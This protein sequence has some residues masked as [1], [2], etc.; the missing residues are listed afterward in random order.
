MLLGTPSH[1]RAAS[2]WIAGHGSTRL[3]QGLIF[4]TILHWG[5]HSADSNRSHHWIVSTV[6]LVVALLFLVTAAR[7]L[8]SDDDPNVP[9]PKWMTMLMSATPAKAFFI[10]VGVITVSVKAWVFTLAAISVI[11]NADLG[12]VANV[13]SYGVFVLLAMSANLLIIGMA[14][15]FGERSRSLLDRTL[16]W[17]QEHNRP[18]MIVVGLVFGIWFGIK[19]LHGFGIW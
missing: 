13:V 4:G 5:A 16:R 10:G 9:P 7:E 17:L 1:L 19:A 2:A 15:L 6:L 3:L 8:F 11:G 18:I 12:R 14:A